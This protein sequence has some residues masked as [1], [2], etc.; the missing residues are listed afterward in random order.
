MKTISLPDELEI[1]SD[2]P[3]HIFDY[4]SSQEISKQQIVLTRNT[5]SFLLEGK[6]EVIGDNASF[7][8]KKSNFLLMKSGHCLMTEKLSS[9]NNNYRSLLLF[10][11]ND[12]LQKFIRTYDIKQSK[13]SSA[14]SVHSF[15][16]DNFITSF[17]Q[18]L[19]DLVILNPK[20]QAKLLQ[21]KFEEI[22]LYLIETRGHDF[23]FS[24]L[25]NNNDQTQH[26]ITVVE[27]N[28][29]NKLTLKELAFL[30]NMSISSFKRAFQK[31]YEMAPMKWF[32]D[33]RLEHAQYLLKQELKSPTEIYQEIGY[34]SLS[35]FIQ[36]F[37]LKYGVTPKQ[38]SKN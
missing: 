7:S 26:F 33:R 8:I 25:R 2:L 3:I 18:S 24:I 10:F 38:F 6:K 12:T 31:E 23:I 16:Y 32:Q 29:L 36:A 30:S 14:Q 22:L 15:A 1:K 34:E 21:L 11:S 9:S 28:R 19:L 35:S 4:R 20:M 13:K 5:F 27:N 37:K 17:V